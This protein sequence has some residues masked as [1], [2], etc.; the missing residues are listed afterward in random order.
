MSES[1]GPG[2]VDSESGS[3]LAHGA[4]NL[5]GRSFF[6]PPGSREMPVVLQVGAGPSHGA[7]ARLHSWAVS[8]VTGPGASGP[9]RVAGR[10]AD[11][12]RAGPA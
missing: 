7:S 12:A 2:P 5:K 3:S 11:M 8:T 1:C 9:G 10:S 6:E 4:P